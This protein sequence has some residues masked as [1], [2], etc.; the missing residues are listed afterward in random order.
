MVH[1][2]KLMSTFDLDYVKEDITISGMGQFISNISECSQYRNNPDASVHMS[3]KKFINFTKVCI[4]SECDTKEGVDISKY[5]IKFCRGKGGLKLFVYNNLVM[6]RGEIYFMYEVVTRYLCPEEFFITTIWYNELCP[7]SCKKILLMSKSGHAFICDN[8]MDDVIFFNMYNA[9]D[10][11]FTISSKPKSGVI[12]F[13]QKVSLG[14]IQ[15]MDMPRCDFYPHIRIYYRDILFGI[16]YRD[17]ERLKD[18][19]G[20]YL[21]GAF[22]DF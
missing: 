12:G 18:L 22:D 3:L 10:I 7:V 21:T 1:H 19:F 8:L 11:E 16:P 2:F 13:D 9:L 14:K 15:T 4:A 6:P 17:W 20:R 5:G